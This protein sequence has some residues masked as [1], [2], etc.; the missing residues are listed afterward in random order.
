MTA[1]DLPT[2]M[3]AR[4]DA[5][6]LPADHKLRQFAAELREAIESESVDVPKL[7][8]R[9]ARARRAW[10]EFTGEELV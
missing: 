2:R 5:D 10:C 4:A 8:G 3:I 1:P 9:W 6:G 7:V